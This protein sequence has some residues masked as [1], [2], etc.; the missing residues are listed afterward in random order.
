MHHG[1]IMGRNEKHKK[2]V[3]T[4][5]FYKIRGKFAKVGERIISRNRREMF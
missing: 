5:Q 2:Y 1:P 4:R 3:K